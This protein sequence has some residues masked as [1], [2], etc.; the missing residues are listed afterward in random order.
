[1]TSWTS[2][3][4][5]R[6]FMSFGLSA[7]MRLMHSQSPLT[8]A[9]PIAPTAVERWRIERNPACLLPCCGLLPKPTAHSFD[10]GRRLCSNSCPDVSFPNPRSLLPNFPKW[11]E[12]PSTGFQSRNCWILPGMAVGLQCL[13]GMF[14][15]LASMVVAGT[16]W[17]S[18]ELAELALL[19]LAL[20]SSS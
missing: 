7:S 10:L 18:E 20:E 15:C 4:I 9:L 12:W 3:T 2:W 1:M 13:P 17:A 14:W 19:E 6:S 8:V 16:S 5:E 11:P